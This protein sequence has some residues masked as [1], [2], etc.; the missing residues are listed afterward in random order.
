MANTSRQGLQQ[1]SVRAR[2][3]TTLNFNDDWQALFT[4]DGIAASPGNWNGRMLAWINLKMRQTFTSFVTAMDLLAIGRGGQGGA[5]GS[6]DATLSSIKR[7][8]NVSYI[9]RRDG[10]ALS[11][12]WRR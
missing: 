7:R 2:T 8:D 12:I 1:E 5:F 9:L 4:L 10:S 6:F 3:G 11:R